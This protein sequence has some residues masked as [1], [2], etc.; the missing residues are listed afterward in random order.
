[1]ID[2]NNLTIQKAQEHLRNKDCSAKELAQSFLNSIEK[3]NP[4]IHAYLEIYDDVLESAE[5]ADKHFKE[6]KTHPLSGIPIAVK[7]N[8]LIDGKKASAS[9]KILEGYVAPY[10]ATIIKKLKSENT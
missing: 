6:G 3:T 2:S 7:D 4:G 9:S 10:D 1:M 8:I 5:I